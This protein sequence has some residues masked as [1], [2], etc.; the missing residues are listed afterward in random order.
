MWATTIFFTKL[1]KVN[2]HPLGENSSDLVTLA[3]NNRLPKVR[4]CS[5]PCSAGLDWLEGRPGRAAAPCRAVV[6]YDEFMT[7]FATCLCR[8]NRM[9]QR[10][11]E[12]RLRQVVKI[13][14]ETLV[15]TVEKK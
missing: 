13:G 11:V 14:R 2:N 7:Y 5:L 12:C 8:K 10:F 15:K 1:P 6:G 9:Q 3:P 4:H